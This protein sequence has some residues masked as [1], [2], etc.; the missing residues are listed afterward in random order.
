[1][2]K[3]ATI[4]VLRCFEQKGQLLSI[5][6]NQEEAILTGGMFMGVFPEV[7]K[8]NTFLTYK[9]SLCDLSECY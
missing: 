5:N 2:L 8:R 3:S 4:I 6:N 1:M 9:Q 7:R